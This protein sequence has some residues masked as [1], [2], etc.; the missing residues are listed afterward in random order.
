MA[1]PCHI[2]CAQTEPKAD[3]AQALAQAVSLADS[4]HG[5]G[6]ELV[7]FPEYCGGL[8]SQGR[9]FTPPVAPE[10]EH[11]VV[12][13]LLEWA[14]KKRCWIVIGSV[15][16]EGPEGKRINRGF[17]VDDTGH[18][19]ARYDKIH[20]FDI[21]LSEDKQFRESD[22]V[23]PGSK[24]VVVN[25]P[26]GRLGLTICYDLRFPQLYRDLSQAGAEILLAP[27]AFTKATGEAH[28]H[29]LNR[30]R[31]IENGAFV[32]SAC[33][34]GRIDGGGQSYGHS[35]IVN[36]WGEI[37]ADGGSLPGVIH[38]IIDLDEVANARTKIPSLS[39]DKPYTLIT[40]SRAVA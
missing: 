21:A 27:S 7:V 40:E 1:R 38:S 20:M 17:V 10:S 35:L 25:T 37:I 32:V 4:A 5:A 11:L 39:H 29:V 8:S 22:T 30:A 2:A 18:I 31:A 12:Q 13:G 24:A 3:W 19:V 28:W 15:A 9:A 6:A 16:I 34:V 26:F 14:A 33:A 36:P 23:D